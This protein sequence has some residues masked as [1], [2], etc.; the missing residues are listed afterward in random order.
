MI[1][2]KRLSHYYHIYSKN[3]FVY[4]SE[5]NSFMIVQFSQLTQKPLIPEN[6]KVVNIKI[7]NSKN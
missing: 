2:N 5:V 1:C 6:G 4:H 7:S 3:Y